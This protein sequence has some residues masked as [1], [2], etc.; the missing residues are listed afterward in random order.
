MKGDSQL[1]GNIIWVIYTL[2]SK[3]EGEKMKVQVIIIVILLISV[4]GTCDYNDNRLQIRNNSRESITVDFSDDTLLPERIK[5]NITYFLRDKIAS[6][7]TFRKNRHG[8]ENAWTFLVQGSANKKLN[9][10][11]INI[12]TLLKYNDWNYIKENQLYKRKEYTLDELEKH[13]WVIEYP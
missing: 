7:E 6:G 8:S 10:F 9:V 1:I 4:A 12:D 13:K 5:E 11:F 3:I 2:D